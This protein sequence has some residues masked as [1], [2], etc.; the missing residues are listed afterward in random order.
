MLPKSIAS[1]SLSGIFLVPHY[2]FQGQKGPIY[3]FNIC[4]VNILLFG[5]ELLQDSA[6]EL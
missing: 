2:Y 1:C 5:M 3:L 6:N 4:L